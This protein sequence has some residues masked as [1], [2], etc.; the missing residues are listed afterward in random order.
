[1]NARADEDASQPC[2]I[3][4]SAQHFNPRY[5]RHLC[6]D[7]AAQAADESGRLLK[8]CNVSFSGGFQAAYADTGETRESH[9]CFVR[10]IRCWA[11]EAYFGG[12]VIQPQDVTRDPGA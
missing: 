12:I 9:I 4:G 2:P 8:F 1:M 10:G 3:C 11:D 7:C 5:P 6:R